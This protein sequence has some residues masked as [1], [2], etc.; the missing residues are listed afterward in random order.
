MA[1]LGGPSRD[2]KGITILRA[3]QGRLEAGEVRPLEP[4]K[5]I[6][7]DVV[8]LKPRKS[9]P[10]LCDVETHLEVPQGRSAE[11]PSKSGA[12]GHASLNGPPQVASDAYRK[13]WDAIYNRGKKTP[14]LL[15]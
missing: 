5:P 10:L 14:E 11:E 12:Q 13:N 8:S 3:R 9:F 15:N 4:G 6:V 1:L 7:G 2:G